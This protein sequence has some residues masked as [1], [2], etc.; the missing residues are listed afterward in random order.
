MWSRRWELYSGEALLAEVRFESAFNSSA[1]ATAAGTAWTFQRAGF[2]LK[3]V[4][5]R[6]AGSDWNAA[7]WRA[8]WAGRKG[9][10]DLNGETLEFRATSFW[11]YRWALF[12]GDGQTLMN[13]SYRGMIRKEGDVTVHTA[14]SGRTDLVM[15]LSLCWYLVMLNA[16]DSSSAGAVA[17]AG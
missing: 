2:L 14:A 7:V 5:V 3:R 4:I 8:H 15:L 1:T 11:G 12:A 9:Q 13:L 16:R 6:A 10:I 17:A